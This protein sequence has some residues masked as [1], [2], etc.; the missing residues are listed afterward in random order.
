MARE[1]SAARAAFKRP[2][3]PMSGNTSSSVYQIGAVC[4]R[5]DLALKNSN[6]CSG[7]F[8]ARNHAYIHDVV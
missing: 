6:R 5:E 3:Q 8:R 1:S 2:E 7:I 4:E